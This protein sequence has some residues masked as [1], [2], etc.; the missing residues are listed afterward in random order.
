MT[1][2]IPLNPFAA[3]FT[4]IIRTLR[5]GV[6]RRCNQD[7]TPK[8][9]IT[10]ICL[11]LSRMTDRFA[12]ILARAGT[13][14][15]PTK[16]RVRKPADPTAEP[17]PERERLPHQFAWLVRFVPATDTQPCTAANARHDIQCLL[18]D[19]EFQALIETTPALGRVL[20]PLYHM[21]G[22]HLPEALRRPRTKRRAKD[23]TEPPK[24]K[25]PRR[26]TP[27]RPSP[28]PEPRRIPTRWEQQ[29]AFYAMFGDPKIFT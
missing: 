6:Q 26:L 25:K 20:R 12:S 22:L 27:P 13:Q 4:H 14:T 28:F 5:D 29:A 19:A 16:P 24:P 11:Y 8:L 3:R 15:P 21:L 18:A 9:L 1:K 17:P 7:R 2:C 23:P 10:L